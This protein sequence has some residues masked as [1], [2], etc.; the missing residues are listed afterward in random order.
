VH[1]LLPLGAE[2][3]I[4]SNAGAGGLLKKEASLW[5]DSN[6]SSS[7]AGAVDGTGRR[8]SMG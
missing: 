1:E 5:V 6:H 7:A 4:P 3:I 2:A 8:Q